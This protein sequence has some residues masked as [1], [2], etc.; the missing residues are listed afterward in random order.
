MVL[1]YSPAQLVFS[2]ATL[3]Y[4]YLLNVAKA[5]LRYRGF[6][7]ERMASFAYKQHANYLLYKRVRLADA[8]EY[9]LLRQSW[10]TTNR[11]K[12]SSKQWS[13]EQAEALR[14][15]EIGVSYDDE[16]IR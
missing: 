10:D 4:E 6:R 7:E 2:N 13:D 1:P 15:L 8:P 12:Y 9:E 3:A 16:D 14:L 11:P 5:D